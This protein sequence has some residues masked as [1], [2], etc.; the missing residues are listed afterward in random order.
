MP[1][2]TCPTIDLDT[3]FVNKVL[4]KVWYSRSTDPCKL[5]K[6]KIKPLSTPS[7][8]ALQYCAK[9]VAN[10][11]S[12]RNRIVSQC[13]M[14]MKP[15]Y[16]YHDVHKILSRNL[17]RVLFH[18]ASTRATQAQQSKP[19]PYQNEPSYKTIG[20]TALHHHITRKPIAA[21]TPTAP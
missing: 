2:R 19:N 7:P 13:P 8:A 17:I 5:G 4:A 21:Y 16:I 6:G 14:R 1:L 12:T 11:L 3:A 15:C 18:R 9:R 20:Y 10:F